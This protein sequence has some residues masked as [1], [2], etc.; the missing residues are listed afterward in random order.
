LINRRLQDRPVTPLPTSNFIL[1]Q[2][3]GGNYA[4]FILDHGHKSV[5]IQKFSAILS[6]YV[7]GSAAKTLDCG[8]DVVG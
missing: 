3:V 2:G 1:R 7:E 8:E 4:F 6:V 5:P